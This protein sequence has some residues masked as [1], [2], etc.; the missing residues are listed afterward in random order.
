MRRVQLLGCL[1][2]VIVAG[3]T[4]AP[5]PPLTPTPS[6]SLTAPA[7]S[8]P[9]GITRIV[10]VWM[11]NEEASGVT[12]SSMPY[13]FGLSTE[14]GR[15]TEMYAVAHPSFPNYLALWSGSTQGITDDRTH[16]FT[17]PSLASQ[18]TEA[19]KQWRVY[20]Q[21]VPGGCFTRASAA[22]K[23]DG[24][25]RPGGYAR[26][27]EPAISF[28]SVSSNATECA[29]IQPLA[30]FDPTAFD[31]AFVA[32]NLCN[33]AHDC[34][35]GVG[36]AF[37]KAFLPSVFSSPDWSHTLLVVSFDEGSSDKNGGGQVFT[38][39]ARQGLSGF[40]SSTTH[41]HYDVLRTIEDTLGLPCLAE[42]CN[43]RPL[44]EFL[45]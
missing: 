37:L 24:P 2:S 22:G 3:C 12:A 34:S 23:S 28:Q 38:L 27:H 16:D 9:T 1:A 4:A 17:A 35:L 19:G 42:A 30:A 20:A 14:Y 6:P 43:A 39:V 18:V 44:S 21:G 32:P 41:T 33:D 29:K 10:V 31:V 26:K 8:S 45:P 36:D 5:T 7:S 25:G 11:E 40:T 15:A 13:L